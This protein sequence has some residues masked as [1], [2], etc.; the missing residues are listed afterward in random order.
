MK[1]L[2]EITWTAY[3]FVWREKRDRNLSMSA[4]QNVP[5][6]PLLS[7]I[8]FGIYFTS[9]HIIHSKRTLSFLLLLFFFLLNFLH[10]RAWKISDVIPNGNETNL[11][12]KNEVF[13][14]HAS[15]LLNLWKPESESAFLLITDVLLLAALSQCL[16]LCPGF[17]VYLGAQ[18]IQLILASLYLQHHFAA[19]WP[20]AALLPWCFTPTVQLR[21][22]SPPKDQRNDC[23]SSTAQTW[24]D[25]SN[26]WHWKRET[27]CLGSFTENKNKGDR[28]LWSGD[29]K[30]EEN[31]AALV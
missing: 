20:T 13:I 10:I 21:T 3:K 26:L 22:C 2:R 16:W 31:I 23:C 25:H 6:S 19:L 4:D 18:L 15:L 14:P 12:P 7:S 24:S 11:H 8:L 5:F 17:S 9:V 27:T 28:D 29:K 1:T 30:A